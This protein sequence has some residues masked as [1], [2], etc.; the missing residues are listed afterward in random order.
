MSANNTDTN[1]DDEST[2]KS[3]APETP[4]VQCGEPIGID[5]ANSA[6]GPLCT[7]CIDSFLAAGQG[8]I[9]EHVEDGDY[10]ENDK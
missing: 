5:S 9:F 6:I 7:I 3:P 8:G 1:Q 10:E 2:G 4:C